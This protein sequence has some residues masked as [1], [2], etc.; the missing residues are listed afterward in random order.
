MVAPPIATVLLGEPQTFI[1]IVSNATDNAV[2]WSVNG[3]SGGNV[4]FGTIDAGGHYNAPANLPMPDSVSV[5]ATSVEDN[6]KISTA[7]VT[8]ASDVTV[9]LSPQTA[10][11]ELGA[12]RPFTAKVNSAGSPNPAVTWNL[13]GSGCNGAACGTVT[14][15][16]I[17][18]APRVLPQPVIVSLIVISVADPSKIASATIDITSTFSLA[19]NGPSSVNAGNSA[20]YIATLIPAANSNPSM[21][22][23][24]SVTGTGCAGASCG[25]ISQ[26]GVYTAP[27]IPP[28]PAIVRIVA[29]PQA[30]P[31]KAA[32][33][34]VTILPVVTIAI[35]PSSASVSLGAPQTFQATVTGALDS[36]VTWDVNG[37]VGGNAAL[38]TILNSQISPN[39]TTYTAPQILPA[40]GSVT[41]HARSNAYPSF[42]GSARA[43]LISALTVNLAPS[44]ATL[45]VNKRQ[46]FSVL[47]N[48]G[49]NQD[50]AWLVNGIAG[51]NSAAGLICMTGSI[52]CQPV[53]A[54]NGGNVDYLAPA[55]LPS[56]NPVTITAMSQADS[57]R[58]ASASVTI[59]P[60]V[61]VSVAPGSVTLASTQQLRF[62]ASVTGTN[63]RIVIWQI[64][65]AGCGNSGACGSIDSSGLYSAP[66]AAPS[67]NLIK[68][69]AISSEDITQSALA[70]VTISNGPAIFSLAP[71]SAYAGTAGG[72]TLLLTGN[73]FAPTIPGPGST[74]LVSGSARTT[75]CVSNTQ[76][77]TSLNAPDLQIAGNLSVQLQNPDGTLSNTQTF[78]VLAPGSGTGT[79][80]LTPSAPTST[81]NDIVVVEL[82]TNGGSGASGN[83]SLNVAAVG[84]YSV[85]T[86]SCALGGSPVVIQR[87]A[88]GNGTGDICVFSVSGL[89]SS[90][91]FAVSG[92]ATP[93]IT[94]INRE[95]LGLGI[96]HLSLLVRA[97]AA[98]GPRTLFI[99]NPAGDK[100]AGTGSIEVQ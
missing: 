51:G 1:A 27:S 46:T 22:I 44:S 91:T 74:I 57:T 85:A 90:F 40:G 65:G 98:P 69:T 6:S 24:W 21:G 13:S 93:D 15:T 76:C 14:S 92:P 38:G 66:S 18:A 87:P 37:V 31:A 70:T 29:T 96:L 48:G 41:V 32:T 71:T 81:D 68:V 56:P 49:T 43:T 82:S 94:V 75:S 9:S 10:P 35:S 60:H 11:V 78:V 72:F 62:S 77:I 36:T 47:V 88:S 7:Q 39:T 2:T 50:V 17:Y 23:V 97:T 55:G 30:D 67:P 58:S 73:N 63:N 79:I 100:A 59:L 83:V 4:A 99:V 25:T 33:F 86:G 53:S 34:P 19:V 42:S 16:G 5:T 12:T 52:P 20:S 28:S 80:P 61:A 45:A 64:T 54:S 3:I 95:P 89:S 26:S 84:A 8:I